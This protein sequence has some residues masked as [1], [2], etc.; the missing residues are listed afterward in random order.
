MEWILKPNTPTIFLC[1]LCND[2]PAGIF[3]LHPHVYMSMKERKGVAIQK[4]IS[5]IRGGV[6]QS[7]AA[8]YSPPYSDPPKNIPKVVIES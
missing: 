6:K 7:P 2:V 3:C 1:P 5:L 4:Q 8:L